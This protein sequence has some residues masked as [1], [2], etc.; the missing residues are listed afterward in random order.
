M[1]NVISVEDGIAEYRGFKIGLEVFDQIIKQAKQMGYGLTI[2][3][4][5]ITLRDQP[6]SMAPLN[7]N[8]PKQQSPPDQGRAFYLLI[9]TLTVQVPP[10]TGHKVICPSAEVTNLPPIFAEQVPVGAVGAIP[11]T[12][13][14]GR[15]LAN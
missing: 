12:E 9:Y 5:L 10:P 6:H 13:N 3:G 8:P 11:D 1:S 7:K 4:N 2:R 15:I 14:P